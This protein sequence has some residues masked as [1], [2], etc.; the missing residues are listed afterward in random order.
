MTNDQCPMTNNPRPTILAAACLAALS[1]GCGTP[2][3]KALRH[4]VIR[5][6]RP[7]EPAGPPI[8]EPFDDVVCRIEAEGGVIARPDLASVALAKDLAPGSCG[9]TTTKE[10]THEYRKQ[11]SGRAALALSIHD[12]KRPDGSPALARLAFRVPESG[13]YYLFLKGDCCCCGSHGFEFGL[14][15]LAKEDAGVFWGIGEWK[16][17]SLKTRVLKKQREGGIVIPEP[18]RLGAGAHTLDIYW[19]GAS[20]EPLVLDELVVARRMRLVGR[21]PYGAVGND[22]LSSAVEMGDKELV[23]MLIA[24]GAE[25]NTFS[26]HDAAPIV[27]ERGGR[28][29]IARILRRHGALPPKEV[30]RFLRA[31]REGD[32]KTVEA[33]LRKTPALLKLMAEYR[34]TPLH[35]VAAEE[36]A[37]PWR[38]RAEQTR[39]EA[40]SE[41]STRIAA[42]LIA[43]EEA[44]SN[45][46]ARIAALFIA[47]GAEVDGRD[48]H[49]AWTPLHWAAYRGSLEVAKVLVAHGADA[50]ARDSQGRTPLHAAVEGGE[51]ELVEFLLSLGVDANFRADDSWS[52]LH[53][54]ANRNEVE[55]TKRLLDHGADVNAEGYDGRTPLFQGAMQ[56]YPEVVRVLLERGA[57]V[58]RTDESQWSPLHVAASGGYHEMVKL[59]LQHGASVDARDDEGRTPLHHTLKAFHVPRWE[60][61]RDYVAVVR[62]LIASGADPGAKDKEGLT[63]SECVPD[64]YRK[65]VAPLLKS[66]APGK[67]TRE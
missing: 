42:I 24:Q 14:D 62:A 53:A 5:Y 7:P 57:A 30:A 29:E 44:Q 4:P 61:N 67:R 34:R 50:G 60:K 11:T 26:W 58:D 2:A 23:E 13:E 21:G 15:G 22:L 55:A 16:W 54:A 25:V 3:P 59:L 64:D 43:R 39:E 6:S 47:K 56:G 9:S 32:F 8:F 51:P 63:A 28:E 10:A 38:R 40:A 12:R 48:D 45:G 66:A 35:L 41:G 49:E 27:G 33:L 17:E 20:C 1:A 31:V 52:P 46:H 19:A 37:V 65:E 18:F 36:G